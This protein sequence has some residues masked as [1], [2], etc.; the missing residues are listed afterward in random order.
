MGDSGTRCLCLKWSVP[1]KPTPQQ[2]HRHRHAGGVWDPCSASKRDFLQVSKKMCPIH[3]PMSGPLAVTLR[4]VFPRPKSHYTKTQ[5]LSKRAP[6]HHI[7]TPDTDNLAKYVLDAL[8]KTYYNDDRQVVCLR[9]VKIWGETGSTDV[10]ISSISK[11]Y[12]SPHGYDEVIHARH[13]P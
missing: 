4:F 10:E 2:R 8:S 7:Q 6:M 3:E 12:F 5:K 13:V 9:V 11:T 1:G